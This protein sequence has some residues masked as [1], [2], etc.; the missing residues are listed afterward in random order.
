MYKIENNH[1]HNSASQNIVLNLN[2]NFLLVDKSKILNNR[3]DKAIPISRMISVDISNIGQRLLPLIFLVLCFD[4][5]SLVKNLS[6]ISGL[7]PDMSRI[8]PVEDR[9]DKLAK[10]VLTFLDFQQLIKAPA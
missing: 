5:A 8:Q 10:N 2:D 1:P 3:I 9:Y 4:M 6:K 7:F